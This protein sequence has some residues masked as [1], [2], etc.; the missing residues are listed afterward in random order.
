MRSIMR[1]ITAVA[2]AASLLLSPTPQDEP[3]FVP[4]FNG[5]N[6][7]GWVNVNC[8]AD[9][10]ERA[11]R[12]DQQH[13]QA[14]LRAAHDRMYENF[15]LELEYQ[16]LDPQGNAGVFIWGDALTARW[17]AVRAGDRGAGSRR[18]EHG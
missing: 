8:A 6:L 15:I 16:H 3:G 4:F 2:L 10:V 7:D 13:R 17:P 12:H 5:R 11:R 9:H 18:P 1:T 14:D